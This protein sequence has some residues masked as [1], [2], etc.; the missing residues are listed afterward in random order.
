MTTRNKK[1]QYEKGTYNVRCDICGFVVK[2]NTTILR[3][4]RV[5]C[6]EDQDEVINPKVTH[7]FDE[8]RVKKSQPEPTDVFL[9]TDEA[10]NS[11]IY[12]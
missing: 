8:E 2:A 5:L 7:R 6:P 4:G 1:L 12:N 11:D 10:E 3:D 9:D